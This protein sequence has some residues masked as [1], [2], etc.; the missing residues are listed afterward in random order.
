MPALN[1]LVS[2]SEN[3]VVAPVRLMRRRRKTFSAISFAVTPGATGMISG[4]GSGKTWSGL[5]SSGVATTRRSTACRSESVRR[6]LLHTKLLPIP[7]ALQALT[8]S[9]TRRAR[10]DQGTEPQGRPVSMCSPCNKTVRG[11]APN[12]HWFES[13]LI[14]AQ[15]RASNPTKR[16][17]TCLSPCV[18]VLS[19][20]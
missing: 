2:V 14:R 19:M 9:F 20:P 6:T 7:L 13:G 8:A 18:F 15:A 5:Q 4:G 3:K 12:V 11:L 10:A 1:M 16:S 17:R